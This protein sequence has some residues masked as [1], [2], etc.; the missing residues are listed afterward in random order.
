MTSTGFA[1]PGL[2]S[3]KLLKAFVIWLCTF[4]LLAPMA[5]ALAAAT[6]TTTTA[7][8]APV[9]TTQVGVPV[10][11]TATVTGTAP[12]G[13]VTFKKGTTTLGT[14]TLTG[15]GNA[16]TATYS[17]TFTTVVASN[18]LT[19]VY[20]GDAVNKTSTSTAKVIASTKKVATAT[21]ASSANPSA[22]GSSVTL[23]ATVTGYNPTGT[24]TF[25]D[26]A[27][28][29]GTGTLAGTGNT[30]TA[31]YSKSNLTVA[32]HSIT[33]VYPGNTLNTS[34]T[35]AALSQVV[36]VVKTAA[37]VTVE[38]SPS[39]STP[40]ELITLTA[41]VTGTAPTGMV[42]FKDGATTLGT[43]TL[44]GTGNTRTAVYETSAL[45][46][47]AS[48]SITAVYAGDGGNLTATS[49]AWEHIVLG[50]TTT[51][52][53]SNANPSAS[54]AA[55]TF[56]ATVTGNALTGT[57]YFFSGQPG[58]YVTLGTS[59]LTG[60]VAT[61]TTSSLSIG[62]SPI[63]ALYTNDPNNLYSWSNVVTQTVNAN[64][65]TIVLSSSVN[66]SAFG[67][68]TTFTAT[69][70]GNAPTGTVTFKDGATTIGSGTLAAGVATLATTSLSIGTHSIT[71]EY[72]GD[73]NNSASTSSAVSQVVGNPSTTTSLSGS[74]GIVVPGGSVTFTATVTGN[75]PTGAVTYK[76]GA[77]TLGTGTL[78]GTGNTRTATYATSALSVGS[79]AVTAVYA[80]NANNAASTSNA[81]AVS[82]DAALVNAPMSMQ[83]GYDAMG[84]PTVAVD[85]YG[86][87]SLYYYDSLGRPIQSQQTNGAGQSL[88]SLEYNAADGIMKFID[89]RNIATTMNP[90]G[91]GQLTSQVSP[92]TGVSNFTF[93]ATGNVTSKTDARGKVTTLAYDALNRLTTVHY[94]TDAD[95]VVEYD[96]GATPTAAAA[97][98]LTKVSDSSG[99]STYTYDDLGRLLTKTQVVNG[100]SF[101]VSYAWGDTVGAMD[102]V[103]AIT[104]PSGNRVDYSYNNL[105]SERGNLTGVTVS[106][107]NPSG[108]GTGTPIGLLSGVTVNGVQQ[109]T[110]WN[111]A[112][113]KT[114]AYVYDKFNQLTAY[115]L[116]DSSGVG[117]SAGALRTVNYDGAGKIMGYSH[118]NGATSLPG[119]NQSFTYDDLGRMT[120]A[121]IG[122]DSIQYN[123]DGTNNRTSKVV[124]G[125]TYTNSISA[126]SNRQV[127]VQDVG[128]T[129]TVQY[130]LAG[131]VTSDGV[132][133][134]TFSD[135]GRL[136]TAVTAG[137]TVSYMYNA[138]DLRVYKAGPTNLV[139]TGAAYFVYDEAGKLLG[140]YDA[141]GTP[142][143]ETIYLGL[144]PV[145]VLKQTG[146][147]QGANIATSVYNVYSDHLATPRVITR[148]TDEAIVWRW[149][150]AESFGATAPDQNP[151]NLGTFVFN[152]RLPG[153]VFD[154]ETGLFQNWHREYNARL[155][156]Y[157]ESDPIG[158]RGGVNTY[159]YVGGNPLS[160]I[161]P[162]GLCLG[163]LAAA[164]AY[165][166]ANA[167]WLVPASI[168]VV[169]GGAMMS[170]GAVSPSSL[171][172]AAVSL[173]RPTAQAASTAMNALQQCS[174][175]DRAA[176]IASTLGRSQGFVTIGV[177]DTAEGFRIISSSENAL[178]P[179][180]LNALRNGEIAVTGLGHAEVT[181]GNAA[182]AMGLTPI[183]TAA[184]R[185]I[186]PSCAAFLENLGIVPLSKLKY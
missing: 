64:A 56:S 50:L 166:L 182:I 137:G 43:A 90:D 78:A 6:V 33:A 46:N 136:A 102:K 3:S 149:D 2:G 21:L 117:A 185:A 54:G 51:V 101:T 175:G 174:A 113:G 37:T 49:S 44:A 14:G 63:T 116:G 146:T 163:P 108:S 111:W 180:A 91:F 183:G 84:R 96:G 114:Q 68:S 36:S 110:G 40:G 158:L 139:P 74:T 79:H 120:N 171:V 125:T 186:C 167:P 106:P 168:A 131:N 83:F 99:S 150:T 87:T 161:D 105:Y 15:T 129:F 157:I 153:Q 22:S 8:T 159:L 81:F 121:N 98:R 89:P 19:A 92:D 179:A 27:T 71:A 164:C 88:Q 148:A 13:T 123:Y 126:T 82:V 16:R 24:V 47:I 12:T 70:S 156:R 133:T 23:T 178:R 18:S 34:V 60:N 169:E 94:Q 160:H 25:K 151:N 73:A 86:K 52:L 32:T 128:G 152:Q 142:I 35:S 38:S 29:L 144:S 62:S 141:T 58:S 124:N 93:D 134:Y 67:A 39:Q 75:A 107:V 1:F 138:A 28:T 165:A 9:T 76:D 154:A 170:T 181:G 4:S 132:N 85:P 7:L 97:G 140:E 26:G 155:G 31:S 17:V 10:L 177:T 42:T 69:V 5:P 130:D 172:P 115:K 109:V 184:S 135:R 45:I 95:T 143:Y 48:H 72:G 145:G 61:L 80:G 30:R 104:Y 176:Q 53:A 100:K 103:T 59:A 122:S 55:V 147:A 41:S 65:S 112:S 118:T 20:A 173:V 66:P 77:T 119:L 127:T 162:T 57:V 11:L